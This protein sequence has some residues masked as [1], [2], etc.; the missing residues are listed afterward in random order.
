MTDVGIRRALYKRVAGA[1]LLVFAWFVLAPP[2][3]GGATTL[4]VVDG[5]SMEPLLHT[6][7]LA[8]AIRKPQ[9]RAG[10]LV[11][12]R[13]GDAGRVIHRLVKQLPNGTWRTRG[14]NK[15]SPDPWFVASSDIQGQFVIGVPGAGGALHRLQGQPLALGGL[16]AIVTLLMFVPFR[17]REETQEVDA[18]AESSSDL[19]SIAVMC[20]VGGVACMTL[21][22]AFIAGG[23]PLFGFA[24]AGLALSGFAAL[25]LGVFVWSEL[26][27]PPGASHTAAELEQV[28]S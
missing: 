13:V 22:I 18:L 12:F 17:R 7:D 14:D 21:S 9:Y 25:A 26:Q 28:T 6:G 27:S 2:Q 20:V 15:P 11:V 23:A 4:V 8:V 1:G 5:T 3:V 19:R 10:D 24:T 16:A